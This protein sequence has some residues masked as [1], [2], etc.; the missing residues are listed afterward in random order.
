VVIIGK[1][2]NNH[3]YLRGQPLIIGFDKLFLRP[4]SIPR[5][6]DIIFDDDILKQMA[7]LVWVEQES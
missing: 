5:E 3:L 2:E 4:P 1:G 6:T 7:T